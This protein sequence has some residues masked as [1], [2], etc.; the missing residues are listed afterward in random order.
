MVNETFGEKDDAKA[1]NIY[2]I[3]NNRI[4]KRASTPL[5]LMLPFLFY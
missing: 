4:N 3:N 1:N 2:N 5:H